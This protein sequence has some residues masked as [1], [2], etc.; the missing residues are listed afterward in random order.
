MRR[1]PQQI[2]V[3][4]LAL[5]ACLAMPSSAAALAP[6]DALP[7]FVPTAATFGPVTGQESA[8]SV[9]VQPDGKVLVAVLN[10]AESDRRIVRLL[11]DGALDPSFG[12]GGVWHQPRANATTVR[13]LALQPDGKIVFVGEDATQPAIVVGRLTSDGVLDSTFANDGLHVSALAAGSDP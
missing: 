12:T 5:C 8:T 10:D 13:A 2:R 1:H 11:A 4:L 7:G 6:G 9:V 3:C